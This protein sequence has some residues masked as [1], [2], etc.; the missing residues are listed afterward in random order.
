MKIL[1]AANTPNSRVTGIAK[2]MNSFAESL[3]K[4]GHSVDL[5]FRE[6][7]PQVNSPRRLGDLL[8]PFFL[9][10]A[11]HRIWKKKGQHDIVALHSL[12]AHIYIFLRQFDKSMPPCVLVSYGADEMRW[13]LEKEEEKLGFRNIRLFSKIF[14][15]NLV[16]RP[17]RFATRHA[18][19]VM[20]A[21][22]CELDYYEKNYHV[23]RERM[24]F[25]PNGVSEKYFI[26][27]S[28]NACRKLLYLGGWEWR[29]GI[30]YLAEGFA[31][32]AEKFPEV[33][34]TLAGIGTDDTEAKRLFP[35]HLHARI[36][37]LSRIS[38]DQTLQVYAN[39]DI[40]VFP[41]LFESMSLVV[42][43]AMAAAM[44]VVTT[45]ACGMQ[46]VIEDGKQGLLVRPRDSRHFAEQTARFIQ[47][48]SWAHQLGIAAQAKAHELLWDNLASDL[49]RL[50][51]STLG[52]PR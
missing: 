5:L 40:F 7:V 26:Q 46:D 39:H 18:D 51:Q 15:Y 4:Q 21:A 42:P 25:V 35:E 31:I 47:E 52:A 11:I 43:E 29:K 44:P 6:N 9:V 14:Y 12:A 32:L 16:I 37:V 30:R 17:A 41:S 8:F 20:T 1:F 45:Q 38:E 19:H 36:Q 34:L 3:R 13:E 2:I 33:T 50:Y 10:A 22:R 48:P 24:T 28:G 23:S 49:I 27:R